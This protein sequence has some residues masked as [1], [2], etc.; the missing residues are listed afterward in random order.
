LHAAG[1][2][3]ENQ[4]GIQARLIA[5]VGEPLIILGTGLC[6]AVIV[7]RCLGRCSSC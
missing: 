3:F 7:V 2:I 6:V 5:V 4:A 1:E